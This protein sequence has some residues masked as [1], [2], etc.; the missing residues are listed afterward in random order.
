MALLQESKETLEHKLVL[1]IMT[2]IE[3]EPQTTQRALSM[4]FGV[5]TGL[6]NTYLKRCIQKGWIKVQQIPTR[7]YAYYVTP[8]GFIEK[9]QLAAKYIYSSFGFFRDAQAQCLELLEFCKQNN[10]QKIA[11]VGSGDLASIAILVSK[12][13]WVSDVEVV[14][15]DNT[16]LL[17]NYDAVIITEVIHPQK[18]FDSLTKIL[19][20]ERIL[21][22][23]LLHISRSKIRGEMV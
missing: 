3:N 13:S 17:K 15:M 6:V 11:F 14:E 22:F 1:G 10:W 7:R 8:K 20:E 9:T 23:P 2:H 5:A 4:R 16:S 12:A 18:T 21:T 19:T